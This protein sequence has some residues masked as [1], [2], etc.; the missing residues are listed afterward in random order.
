MKK[1]YIIPEAEVCACFSDR[2]MIGAGEQSDP[3]IRPVNRQNLDMSDPTKEEYFDMS[4]YR[5]WD[6]MEE[7]K[8]S[9]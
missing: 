8:Y 3:T 1:T 2:I 5:V 6:S 9:R 4:E 7:D